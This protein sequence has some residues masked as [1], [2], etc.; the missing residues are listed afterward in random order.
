MQYSKIL[1]IITGIIFIGTLIKGF[2]MDF[3]AV[4]DTT[5]YVSG[6][7]IS[8][9]LF[10][11]AIISYLRK[12]QLEN[13]QKIKGNIYS[14]ATTERLRFI[15]ESYK[16]KIKYGMTDSDIEEAEMISPMDEFEND[17]LNSMSLTG[18]MAM[19]EASEKVEIQN[20]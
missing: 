11:S 20:Y 5:F 1:P 6:L 18:D 16:L 3:G 9:G 13:V 19:D 4:M 15:E 17:A 7:T 10:G 14:L 12:A 8:G 2:T